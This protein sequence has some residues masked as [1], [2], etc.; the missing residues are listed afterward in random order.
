[1]QDIRPSQIGTAVSSAL[2]KLLR[3]PAPLL[4]NGHAGFTSEDIERLCDTIL[5]RRGA[6]WAATTAVELL[7]AYQ[8]AD[9]ERRNT[10]LA[11]LAER[12]GGDP[13]RLDRAIET[14]LKERDP[15]SM[16]E[17]HAASESRRHQLIHELNQAPGGTLALLRMREHGLRHRDAIPGFEALDAD[18]R[19]V[20]GSWF[21]RGF[22]TLQR[23]DWS[24]PAS[25]LR[26]IIDYEAVHEIRDWD[27]LRRRV[28]PQDRRCYA[29]FH[30]QLPEEPLIFVEIA[31]T[32]EIPSS[33]QSVLTHEQT[34]IRAS[35]PSTAVFYSISNCQLGLRG[36]PFGSFLIKQT[37]ELLKSELP[38]LKTFVTLSPV[39]SFAGWVQQAR[40]SDGSDLLRQD[41]R[42]LLARLDDPAWTAEPGPLAELLPS[43]L[44]RYLTKALGRDGRPLDPVAK[45]HL[46]NGARLEHVHWMA[47][48]SGKG[49]RESY[50]MM[51]NYLYDLRD[52]EANQLALQKRGE[53]AASP[54]M[55]KLAR[56][57]RRSE[58]VA[59]RAH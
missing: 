27:D 7:T 40:S 4:Q 43:M 48:V 41:E 34:A 35:G 33:I 15:V 52:I 16:A 56:S 3:R 45:F 20:L 17:V 6:A 46:G 26:K 53:I 58:L 57:P 47:D 59:A 42:E 5:S 28:E 38:S 37:A 12:Y 50:G 19:Q 14:Y 9:D 13:A 54:A 8:A 22:L 25:V 39:P 21:N 49:W 55:H 31:L 24:S 30:P 18:F 23:I 11:L 36:V 32:S 1:M 2:R 29:L 44:A 51:V 10:F